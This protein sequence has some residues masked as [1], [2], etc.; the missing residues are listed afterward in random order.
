MNSPITIPL[1]PKSYKKTRNFI[2]E[3]KKL[4]ITFDNSTSNRSNQ[5]VKFMFVAPDNVSDFY[6]ATRFI[7]L[8][9]VEKS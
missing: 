9:I 5:I 7:L 4:L 6:F 3:E 8:K 2:S 1:F